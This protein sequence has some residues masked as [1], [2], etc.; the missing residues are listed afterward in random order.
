MK[1]ETDFTSFA[2]LSTE[3]LTLRQLKTTDEN[4]IFFLRS[5]EV[6]NQFI[7]R[8]RQ[9]AL[10]EAR[11][12][13]TRI[14]NE[15]MENKLL[16][17]AITNKE[18]PKLIATICLWK[19]SENKKTAEVGYELNSAFQGKGIMDEALKKIINFSFETLG[20]ITLEAFTHKDNLKSKTL[21]IK[22]NFLPD[23]TRKDKDH[24]TNIIFIL[25]K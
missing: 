16:Y 5:D 4:E 21:L 22:N 25:R 19:F 8:P 23:I 24:P 15:I 7:D 9:K 17:W 10:E 18:N 1:E 2:D 11:S 14:N 13:I 6:I 12:F 20:L 3:R